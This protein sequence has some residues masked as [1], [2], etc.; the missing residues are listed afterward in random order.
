M[1]SRTLLAA[2]SVL[3]AATLSVAPAGA[4]HR[5]TIGG[6]G[7]VY[8]LRASTHRL[9]ESADRDLRYRGP[10]GHAMAGTLHRMEEWADYYVKAVERHGFQSW[11]ARQRFDRFLTEYRA[12]CRFLDGGRP[13]GE[14]A[15]LHSTVDRLSHAYGYEV[16]WQGDHR[17]G[18][19][20]N[21]DRWEGKR[22][23]RARW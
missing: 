13:R 11:M 7:L 3:V 9:H 14:V 15:V 21:D 2:T 19:R 8:Q 12:A 1:R 10:R 16:A 6:P 5:D 22:S 4:A 23:R 20:W 18:G 17:D